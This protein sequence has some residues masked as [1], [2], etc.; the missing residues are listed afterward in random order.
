MP[1]AT[2][3]GLAMFVKVILCHV[4]LT[5]RFVY[6]EEYNIQ[7]QGTACR[8]AIVRLTLVKLHVFCLTP[9]LFRLVLLRKI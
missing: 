7:R 9:L 2:A 6:N 4:W 5:L 8:M 3:S 1:L